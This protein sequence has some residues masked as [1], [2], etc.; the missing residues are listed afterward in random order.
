[1]PGHIAQA[2]SCVTSRLQR[3]VTSKANSS[4]AAPA[5]RGDSSITLHLDCLGWGAVQVWGFS[6]FPTC[7]SVMRNAAAGSLH[8]SPFG[9]L[10]APS[11][12]LNS[13]PQT[14]HNPGPSAGLMPRACVSPMPLAPTWG[15][16]SRLAKG[17]FWEAVLG[18]LG[19][20]GRQAGLG[21][22]VGLE[23]PKAGIRSKT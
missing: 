12:A 21:S 8:R 9:C 4:A 11:T 14:R 20:A 3:R 17:R 7:M 19:W 16:R 22:G 6:G 2:R 5:S 23:V 10:L 15:R 13:G 18:G 1:M